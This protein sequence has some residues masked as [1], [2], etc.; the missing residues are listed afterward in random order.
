VPNA[1]FYVNER[2]R[3]WKQNISKLIVAISVLPVRNTNNHM[4][5]Y[6]I[7]EDVK[8]NNGRRVLDMSNKKPVFLIFLRHFGCIFCREGLAE[9]AD[10]KKRLFKK[11]AEIV[12]FH[13]SDNATADDYFEHFDL[14]DTEHVADPECIIYQK[15]GLAKGNFNQLFGLKNWMRGFNATMKGTSFSLKHIGDAF[16]MPGVFVLCDGEIK[17]SYIHQIASDKPNYEVL[18]KCCEE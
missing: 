7:L 10:A 1:L 4:N 6:D 12:F 8:T 3:I 17:C 16:Q 11:G 18:S 15:F 13:M 2:L 9:I 14:S 5:A